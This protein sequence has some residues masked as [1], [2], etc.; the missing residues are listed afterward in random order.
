MKKN[1]PYELR[2]MDEVR[3]LDSKNKYYY[4]LGSKEKDKGKG[5]FVYFYGYVLKNDLN[6]YNLK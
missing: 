6:E 1:L 4:I 5:K 2:I 3:G